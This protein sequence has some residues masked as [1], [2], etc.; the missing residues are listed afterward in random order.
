MR[1]LDVYLAL[2]RVM[3]ELDNVGDP[4]ADDI[5][6]LMEPIWYRLTDI[7][8]AA[9][10]SRGEIDPTGLFPVQLPVPTAPESPTP[11]IADRA[12]ELTGWEAP[13]D[14]GKQAA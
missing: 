2:E 14:G 3:L 5:R 1:N 10:D 9:L 8:I 4:I 13:A 6:D 12:F 11:T 7:E